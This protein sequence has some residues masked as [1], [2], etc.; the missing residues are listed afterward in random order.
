MEAVR[1]KEAFE[2]ISNCVSEK[3]AMTESFI[4]EIHSLNIKVQKPKRTKKLDCL[5]LSEAFYWKIA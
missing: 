4:K 5:Y 1:H 2:Y 3:A